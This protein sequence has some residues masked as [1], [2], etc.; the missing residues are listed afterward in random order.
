MRQR[1]G[2]TIAEVLLS[3]TVGLT[4][5][6]AATAFATSS[7]K[8]RRGWTVRESIDRNARFVGL[9]LARDMQEA[10]VAIDDIALFG[11]LAT[12]NDTI[13]ALSVPYTPNEAPVYT[14]YNDGGASPTYPAGGNC[15]STCIEFLTQ[16]STL[17]LSAGDLTRLQVGSSRRLL[18]LSSVANQGNGRF[19]V[20]F[21][22]VKTLIGRPSGLDSLLLTRSGSTIQKLNAVVYWRD[23]STN[24]LMRA[25]TVDAGGKP[26]GQLMA[27]NVLGFKTTLLFTSGQEFAA[28]N[29]ADTD[30]LNDANDILGTRIRAQFQSDRT[31]PAVN[32]G[33][34]VVRWYEW[35][36]SPRNLLYEKNR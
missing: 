4:I 21:L 32:G 10:G 17:G 23:A 33:L 29:G 18:L 7:W 30:T 28:Y 12:F 3:M 31:D 22:N 5:I 13:S 34:P 20:E 25:T 15:G 9:S 14:I 19:R 26:Q 16:G 35:K 24:S 27:N 6:V 8:T 36:V 11:T 1:N 2:F